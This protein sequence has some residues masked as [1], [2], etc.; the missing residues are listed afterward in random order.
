MKSLFVFLSLLLLA[1]P[2][3]ARSSTKTLP[4]M[5]TVASINDGTCV[6]EKRGTVARVTD[7]ANSADCLTGGGTSDVH[8]VYDGTVWSAGI[9][10]AGGN[11]DTIV[12]TAD[13]Q[14]I[15]AI[16]EASPVTLSCTD[17]TGA[18]SMIYDAG[19]AGIIIIGSGDVLSVAIDSDVGLNFIQNG[20]SINNIADAT[21]DFTRDDAGVVTLTCSDNNDACGMIYDAG[22]N[23]SIIL[24]SGDVSTIDLINNGALTLGAAATTDSILI[25]TA[26][27][28]TLEATGAIVI[29]DASAT[30]ITLGTDDTGDGT[31]LVLPANGV[32]SSEINTIVE[33]YYWTAT[34][35]SADGTQC[36][37]A[38]QES[39][40][41]GPELYVIVCADN[42]A[43]LIGGSMVMPDGWDAGTV[44][45]EYTTIQTGA[46][47]L[48][49]NGDM[50]VQCRGAGEAVVDTW[51]SEVAMDDAA[52]I[53]SSATDT[54][55][56]A[57][58]TPDGTCVAGD[59]LIWQ[60]S[61]DAT[62]TT[63]T[64]ATNNFIGFKMEYTSN[65]GD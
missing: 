51:S 45:F 59:L 44:T 55:T 39:T 24:G 63:A 29:G 7:G 36:A 60:Y 54:I 5:C 49:V 19:G 25:Q 32:D 10:L 56:S 18:C 15:F 40:I 14:F 52:Q 64:V 20:D 23:G 34:D 33:S 1:T 58:I 61:V 28:I 27:T 21:F 41:A 3:M 11:G 62:G 13:S 48:V 17:D 9:A 43:G 57:A 38:V 30:V 50:E 22:D 31:D 26:G 46:E 42:D 37:D 16:D 47:T 2:A 6:V 8:C 65:V 35:L 12:N 53:G 4:P